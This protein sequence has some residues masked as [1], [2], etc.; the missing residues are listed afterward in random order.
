MKNSVMGS[1][2]ISAVTTVCV[3]GNCPFAQATPSQTEPNVSG[4]VSHTSVW[5]W[6]FGKAALSKSANNGAKTS[7]VWTW[8]VSKEARSPVWTEAR[9]AGSTGSSRSSV[10]KG[11]TAR[12][13]GASLKSVFLGGL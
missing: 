2:V 13:R 10:D 4:I 5:T 7:K 1:I 3:M 11:Q 9:S 6:R 12:R 8:P